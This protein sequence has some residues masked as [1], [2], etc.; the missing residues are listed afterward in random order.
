MFLALLAC[1][2]PQTFLTYNAGL[3]VGFVPGAEDRAQAT[4]DAVNQIDADLVCLQEVWRP[5]HAALFTSA[6]AE[7]YTPEAQ[8]DFGDGGACTEDD[9]LT[10]TECIDENC[11][12]ACTDELVDCV[13][14]ACAFP[15]LGLE[16]GCQSCVMANVGGD[17]DGVTETCT[18][19][20]TKFAY[21]GSFGTALLSPHP[22]SGIEEHVFS[23]TTNRRSV[24]HAVMEG[25]AG[26]VDIYC[27]HLTAVFD[28]IPY[29]GDAGSWDEEQKNQVQELRDFVDA[30]ST[31]PV[32]LLGDF[33]NGPPVGSMSGDNPSNYA[34]LAQGYQNPYV[35]AE[36]DCTYCSSNA[37]NSEDSQ[38]RVIDHVLTRDLNG[39]PTASRALDEALDVTS[40]DETFEAALSDHYGVLVTYE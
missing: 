10:L 22:L 32:V 3:A 28:L 2:G 17:I 40:C 5:D 8:Q 20:S 7:H 27:T 16:E 39:E 15:F 25:P 19:E 35:D 6:W 37:L 29:T 36:L 21:D 33:N 9:L 4:A 24:L 31:N 18:T 38:D 11:A 12:D 14:D 1:N 23:S 34:D 30:T 26:D 13:F